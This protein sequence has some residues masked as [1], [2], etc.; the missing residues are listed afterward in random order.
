MVL[1]SQKI[2]QIRSTASTAPLASTPLHDM[3]APSEVGEDTHAPMAWVQSRPPELIHGDVYSAT[4]VVAMN[5]PLWFS[6]PF[7]SPRFF[8]H[9]GLRL[10]GNTLQLSSSSNP[11]VRHFGKSTM[12]FP[13]EFSSQ[14]GCDLDRKRD[15]EHSDW[16]NLRRNFGTDKIEP[17]LP[18]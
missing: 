2:T 9:R 10:A 7:P 6:P 18:F 5:S 1:P 16:Q 12:L 17:N 4:H 11:F 13:L 3:T 14:T 8:H 15:R